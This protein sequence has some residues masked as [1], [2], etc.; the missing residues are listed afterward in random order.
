MVAPNDVRGDIARMNAHL[1]RDSTGV[2]TMFGSG[3]YRTSA[4]VLNG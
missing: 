4:V 2:G 1:F 3:L